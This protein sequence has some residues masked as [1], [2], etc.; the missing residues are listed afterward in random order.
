[1]MSANLQAIGSIVFARQRGSKWGSGMLRGTM[2]ALVFAALGFLSLHPFCDLALAANGHG[3]A[4][5]A[6]AAVMHGIDP[7]SNPAHTP[8]GACCE[9]VK[10]GT[11]VKAAE[12]L[13]SWTPGGALGAA[14]FAFA[15]LPLLA[16]SRNPVRAR[17]TV[18]PE[19]S[20]YAR[21]T[22]ILR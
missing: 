5:R 8:S 20:F 4:A 12:P 14:L 9:T 13:I 21:S 2:V 1:M 17:L 22:R 7:D 18:R 19:R 10:D 6:V 11:L 15:G 16:S 3:D